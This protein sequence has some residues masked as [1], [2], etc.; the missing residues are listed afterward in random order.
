MLLNRNK[1]V[2][3]IAPTREKADI[4]RTYVAENIICCPK[5]SVLLDVAAGGIER[6]KNEVSKRKLTLKNG[7]SFKVLSA[8]G[9]GMSLMGEGGDLIIVDETGEK[10]ITEDV[11]TGKI[12]RMLADSEDSMIIEIGNP[13]DPNSHFA[14][15]WEDPRSP[16]DNGWLKFH[17]GWTTGVAE[18]RISQ[19]FIEDRRLECLPME[20][21]VLWE[22]EFP[23]EAEDQLIKR[24]WFDNALN[25]A[26]QIGSKEL[27][28]G[29][30]VAEFGLDETVLIT[31][32]G[33]GRNLVTE[34]CFSWAKQETMQTVSHVTQK[35]NKNALLNVDSTGIGSGVESRLRELGHKTRAY[36]GGESPR[37]HTRFKNCLAEGYWQLRE[38]FEQGRIDLSRLKTYPVQLAK[39]KSQLMAIKYEI[40]SDR[41]IRIRKPEDKSPDYADAL[42]LFASRHGTGFSFGSL[43]LK[44]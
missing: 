14:K 22:A 10:E 23:E 34:S 15:H 28:A 29:L 25:K 27:K 41:L 13:W 24:E 16:E 37:D 21:R 32:F 7:C 31:G 9:G 2:L 30:D 20:F 1:K 40:Q 35:L 5:M 12:M 39:L 11:F 19:S 33:D 38:I 43:E 3:L 44:T 36:K 26:M 17:I 8:E 6:I 4:M 42:M 18:D